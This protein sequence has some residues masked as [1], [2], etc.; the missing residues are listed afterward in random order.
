[1]E[2]A[3]KIL[4]N[5]HEGRVWLEP[6]AERIPGGLWLSVGYLTMTLKYIPPNYKSAVDAWGYVN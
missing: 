6:R 3:N 5:Y 2:L 4:D 1:M